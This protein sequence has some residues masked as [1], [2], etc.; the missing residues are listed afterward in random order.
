M[1]NQRDRT[2]LVHYLSQWCR[3]CKKVKL[4]DDFY[5]DRS[6]PS[7]LANV[8]KVCGGKESRARHAKNYKNGPYK[9]KR[10]RTKYGITLERYNDLL[11]A[12]GGGCAICSG[13]PGGRWNTFHVDHDH[14]T[15]VVRGLLCDACNKGLGL[16]RD[17]PRLLVWAARYLTPEADKG[18]KRDHGLPDAKPEE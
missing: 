16:F 2:A 3:G 1:K 9:D 13:D 7:G 5:R 17:N 8:C 12:Q 10:L 14:K 4:F 18:T 6:R 15:G 11:A